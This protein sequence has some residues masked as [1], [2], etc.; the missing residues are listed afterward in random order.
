MHRR[1]RKPIPPSFPYKPNEAKLYEGSLITCSPV[2]KKSLKSDPY[3][4][5]ATTCV[6]KRYYTEERDEKYDK[7]NPEYYILYKSEP[8]AL[9]MVPG[10]DAPPS[11]LVY[12]LCEAAH[13]FHMDYLHQE[14]PE[15]FEWWKENRGTVINELS[16]QVIATGQ[17][18]ITVE[19]QLAR[20]YPPAPA[21]K[22]E[23]A[24]K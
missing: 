10:H 12:E 9:I 7:D 6:F 15:L 4:P 2:I 3:D 22:K 18:W 21:A 17:K 5:S 20:L 8:V 11:S 24:K 23:P 14:Y 19:E 16:G 13:N 1:R